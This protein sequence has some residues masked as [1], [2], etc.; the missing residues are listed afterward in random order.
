MSQKLQELQQQIG[1]GSRSNKYR[2]LFPYFGRDIDIQ[3]HEIT[4]P[5]RNIGV[6][7]VYVKGREIK[8]AGDRADEGSITMSIYNDPDLIIRR[9]FL[10]VIAGI[11]NYQ[12]PQS[13]SDSLSEFEDLLGT[14]ILNERIDGFTSTGL[15][16]SN[17]LVRNTGIDSLISGTIIGDALNVVTQINDAY[18][19]IK[20]NWS[21]IRNFVNNFN[22][23]LIPQK[24]FGMM[25]PSLYSTNYGADYVGDYWYQTD[26][27]IQQLGPNQEVLTET[28]LW[29]AFVSSVSEIQYSDE[30]GDITKTS[31]TINYSGVAYGTDIET[32]YLEKY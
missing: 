23:N 30:T 10:K 32:R 16:G 17:P 31:I 26:I 22:P 18:N 13:L 11:Q 8:V 14:A 4:S 24:I 25:V 29:N 21:S 27:K 20:Y 9:F 6:V 15:A 28:T 7:D 19:E 3:T 2:V 1:A 5:G 12:T